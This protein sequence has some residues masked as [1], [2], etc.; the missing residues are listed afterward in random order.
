MLPCENVPCV[1]DDDEQRPTL[2][3][4]FL[5]LIPSS[6]QEKEKSFSVSI[7]ET[8]AKVSTHQLSV[9]QTTQRNR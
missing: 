9:L 6:L 1:A 4:F 3:F 5:I 7:K 2:I 8:T